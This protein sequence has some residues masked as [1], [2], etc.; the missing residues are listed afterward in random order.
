MCEELWLLK[1]YVRNYKQIYLIVVSGNVDY[2]FLPVLCYQV[3]FFLAYFI[4]VEEAPG[5]TIVTF[6]FSAAI[7]PNFKGA[8]LQAHLAYMK[9]V[10]KN[11][12]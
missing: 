11:V 3:T 4:K 10:T 7:V 9:N 2:S 8:Q 6:G 5:R 1:H 12:P